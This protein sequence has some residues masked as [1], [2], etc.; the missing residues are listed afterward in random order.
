M[1]FPDHSTI[2]PVTFREP[3]SCPMAGRPQKRENKSSKAICF[4]IILLRSGGSVEQLFYLHELIVVEIACRFVA[5]TGTLLLVKRFNFFR[6]VRS[7]AERYGC[8]RYPAAPYLYAGKKLLLP[9]LLRMP[10]GLHRHVGTI[11]QRDYCL[12]IGEGF[13]RICLFT[14]SGRKSA[15]FDNDGKCSR[16]NVALGGIE[17]FPLIRSLEQFCQGIVEISIEGIIFAVV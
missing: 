13:C 9:D 16:L 15:V 3:V 12:M 7:S 2:Y 8:W 6:G 17:L 4:I 11:S 5:C 14:G 1:G 10:Y